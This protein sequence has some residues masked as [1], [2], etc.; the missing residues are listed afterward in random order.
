[1]VLVWVWV[2]TPAIVEFDTTGVE[3]GDGDGAWGEDRWADA[4]RRLGELSDQLEQRDAYAAEARARRIL[5]GLGFDE[6]T[7]DAPL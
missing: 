1:M 7:Q 6:K 3:V 2:W 5:T 4:A